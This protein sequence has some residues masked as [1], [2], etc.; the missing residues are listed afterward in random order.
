M[1][2]F[3]LQLSDHDLELLTRYMDLNLHKTKVSAI[4]SLLHLPEELSNK[5][6]LI[7]RLDTQLSDAQSKLEEYQAYFK[8]HKALSDS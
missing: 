5:R 8:L 4:R 3:N 1:N 7:N 6:N 2:T